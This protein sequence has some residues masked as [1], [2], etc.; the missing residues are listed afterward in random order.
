MTN[1]THNY[2]Q[3]IELSVLDAYGLLETIESD[4]FNRSFHDAPA[5]VQDEI[6][7]M[8]RDFALDE[9]L[10]PADLP[11]ASLKQLVLNSVAKAADKEA[12]RLAPLA[13]IGAR[14]SAARSQQGSSTTL[15]FWRI[16][17]LVLFGVS[18]A[19]GVI[20]VDTKEELTKITNIASN[21]SAAST[22]EDVIGSKEFKSFIGDPYCQVSHFIETNS[23]TQPA[24][25]RVAMNERWGGGYIIGLDLTIG[26]NYIIQGTTKSGT[27]LELARFTADAS[28]IGRPFD[29]SVS[30]VVAGLTV[31]V[32]NAKTGKAWS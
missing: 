32:I 22:L 14:A 24:F 9:S 25:I 31:T 26:S 27:V 10:L 17:S 18:V 4:L 28:I 15:Y 12:Q 7:R 8:Q 6:I 11:P 19:L 30:D 29:I 2:K 20:V 5:S 1:E 13:L 23:K 21:N 16:A 3:L